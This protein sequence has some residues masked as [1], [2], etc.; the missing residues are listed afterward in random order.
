MTP[1]EQTFFCSFLK[2]AYR[3]TK[4][5]VPYR[6]NNLGARTT[7]GK[8]RI[9]TSPSAGPAALGRSLR[10]RRDSRKHQQ[11]T[12]AP[13][14][15]RRRFTCLLVVL[16][17]VPASRSTFVK[18]CEIRALKTERRFCSP[19]VCCVMGPTV[20]SPACTGALRPQ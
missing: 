2:G 9:G 12:P 1:N 7:R 8:S 11:E 19:G 13:T 6:R 17:L 16:G 3:L 10:R 15:N 4:Y 20:D 18:R 5:L 14:K